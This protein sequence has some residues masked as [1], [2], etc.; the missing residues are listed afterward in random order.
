MEVGRK[1]RKD[2]GQTIFNSDAK[3][4]AVFTIRHAFVHYALTKSCVGNCETRYKLIL[5]SY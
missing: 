1:K 4:A 2:A 5:D 3:R